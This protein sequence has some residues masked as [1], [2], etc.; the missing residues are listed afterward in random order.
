MV[1]TAAQRNSKHLHRGGLQDLELLLLLDIFL[2]AS[3]LLREESKSA[4]KWLL[5]TATTCKKF[6]S[7]ALTALYHA[8]AI[9]SPEQ[10]RELLQHLQRSSSSTESLQPTHIWVNHLSIDALPVLARKDHGHEPTNLS[11][12][13]PL[14]PN[15]RSLS[16]EVYADLPRHK[17]AAMNI[18]AKGRDR[19]YQRSWLTALADS[20][21][22]LKRF[23]W[24]YFFNRD[25]AF[26]WYGLDEIHATLA[27]KH[28]EHIDVVWLGTFTKDANK[29]QQRLGFTNSLRLLQYLKG[30]SFTLCTLDGPQ[31]LLNDVPNNLQQMAIVDCDVDAD[32]LARYLGAR[33]HHL[34]KLSLNHNRSL[35]LKFTENLQSSCPKLEVLSID[36]SCFG[37]LI[38]MTDSEPNFP[39]LLPAESYPTWPSTLQH[40]ELNWLRKWGR[41]G[42]STFFESIITAAPNL[43][44]LR[45]L[46]ISATVEMEWR[47]R[48]KF[49][50]EWNHKFQRVFKRLAPDPTPISV[51]SEIGKAEGETSNKTTDSVRTRGQKR[52]REMPS[53][54]SAEQPR[55]RSARIQEISKQPVAGVSRGSTS[56]SDLAT[57]PDLSIQGK[58]HRVEFKI[59][60][61]RPRETQYNEGDF[62]DE[63]MSGDDDWTGVDV[64]LND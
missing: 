3:Q 22:R 11:D 54:T 18:A 47:E 1:S 33:G 4:Q 7:P 27:F 26:P 63:E 41:E 14:A 9:N 35:N 48:P 49:R 10:A 53:S 44:D 15:L 29:D 13:L 45:V 34:R 25:Q 60:N 21:I 51:R 28:V 17:R 59:S 30:L 61:L 40:L 46:V 50:D 24:N 12:L 36:L 42:A 39:S 31:P 23:K 20:Q 19:I 55:K 43:S 32:S 38:S 2:R 8:P 37:L 64:E 52:R 56:M 57:G 62:L 6:C 58:C 16:L 5:Q